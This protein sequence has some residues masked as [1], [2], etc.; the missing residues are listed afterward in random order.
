M[1]LRSGGLSSG[2]RGSLRRLGPGY[3]HGSPRLFEPKTEGLP[4]STEN[5]HNFVVV[6][7]VVVLLLL[8][9]VA[10]IVPLELVLHVLV[11]PVPELDFVLGSKSPGEHYFENTSSEYVDPC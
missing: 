7:V 1:Y 2:A 9:L 5:A 8:L 10:G 4:L 11:L 3:A 6:V